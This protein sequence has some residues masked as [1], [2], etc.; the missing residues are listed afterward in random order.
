VLAVLF[1]RDLGLACTI[2]RK[3]P[4]VRSSQADAK[5]LEE[6]HVQFSVRLSQQRDEEELII[7]RAQCMKE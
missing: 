1:E 7:A 5:L 6:G 4:V 2:Y 3:R